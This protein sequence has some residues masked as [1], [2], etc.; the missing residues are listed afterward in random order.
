MNDQKNSLWGGVARTTAALALACTALA[1]CAEDFETESPEHTRLVDEA[2]PA[3]QVAPRHD[4]V[5][6]DGSDSAEP[7][8]ERET[9]MPDRRGPPQPDTDNVEKR[10]VDP[11]AL[12]QN[13]TEVKRNR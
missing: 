7:R 5:D 9:I 10:P 13:I 4:V 6:G 3:V 8:G 12:P 11:P 2:A 1:S